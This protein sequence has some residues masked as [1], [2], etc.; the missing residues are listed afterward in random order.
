MIRNTLNE[1]RSAYEIIRSLSKLS[2]IARKLFRWKNATCYNI[3][4][5]MYVNIK[6]Y[7]IKKYNERYSL[8]IISKISKSSINDVN[9]KSL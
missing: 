9:L 5:S 6:N 4:I 8:L 1:T 3:N 7:N 2:T